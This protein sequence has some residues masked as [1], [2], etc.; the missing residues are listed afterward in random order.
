[1]LTQTYHSRYGR[2]RAA[3][4][5]SLNF[6]FNEG[7]YRKNTLRTDLINIGRG[8]VCL[9]MRVVSGRGCLR[10]GCGFWCNFEDGGVVGWINVAK[11]LEILRKRSEERSLEMLQK[12]FELLEL[13]H[14]QIRWATATKIVH[15]ELR[16]RG[17]QTSSIR[18]HKINV[19]INSP[20]LNYPSLLFTHYVCCIVL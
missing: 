12:G 2:C 10:F 18:S 14:S 1:M 15:R 6:K 8:V 17:F 16:T 4:G 3:A 7:C 13:H 11:S 9:E 19:L 5:N 20:F